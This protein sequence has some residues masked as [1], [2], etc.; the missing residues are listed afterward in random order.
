[1][2]H[3]NIL[4]ALVLSFPLAACVTDEASEDQ[5]EPEL[6]STTQA[7]TGTSVV[8]HQCD[9]PYGLPC[10]IDLGSTANNRACFIGGI[11]GRLDGGGVLIWNDLGGNYQMMLAAPS[12]TKIE[13]K[14]VCI[15]GG[16]NR[17]TMTWT[18]GQPY[19]VVPATPN[20]HCFLQSISAVDDVAFNDTTDYIHTWKNG[21]NYYLGG[22]I[23]G[24]ATPSATAVCIDTPYST[25]VWGGVAVLGGTAGGN[26][27]N[28][29]SGGW[30][31]GFA[32]FGGKFTSSSYSDKLEL[33]Y[34]SSTAFWNWWLVN[35]K[36]AEAYCVK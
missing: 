15:T 11:S 5:P 9:Q 12:G 25:D 28:N 24:G 20:R 3:T 26:L 6:S 19:D 22:Q 17:T 35:G 14:T 10:F 2:K 16:T 29:S 13:A 34:N 7:I 36:Q 8:T 18:A 21:S 33:G 31:C 1:M 32:K 27:V 4:S 23:S 30:A